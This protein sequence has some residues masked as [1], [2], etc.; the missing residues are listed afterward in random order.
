MEHSDLLQ[1]VARQEEVESETL[2]TWCK[3]I[4][5]PRQRLPEGV[6]FVCRLFR[7][8][9]HLFSVCPELKLAKRLIEKVQGQLQV[10]EEEEE[11]W[12]F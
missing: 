6:E 4:H 5:P 12:C 11:V 7:K 1:A 2:T 3:E 8:P 9:D 10:Q